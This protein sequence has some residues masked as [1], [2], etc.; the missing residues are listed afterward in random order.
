MAKISI[1][2]T[3]LSLATSGVLSSKLSQYPFQL[4]NSVLSDDR[5][6]I[7]CYPGEK[8]TEIEDLEGGGSLMLDV[9][10]NS[11]SH[12]SI[13]TFPAHPPYE[14]PQVSVC[15]THAQCKDKRPG[16]PCHLLSDDFR[17][18][19]YT[20]IG[21]RY[22]LAKGRLDL[23]RLGRHPEDFLECS[24]LSPLV[25]FTDGRTVKSDGE[26]MV[27]GTGGGDRL[28]DVSRFQASAHMS[29][30]TTFSSSEA[31]LSWRRLTH[32]SSGDG[33]KIS[34]LSCAFFGFCIGD[35]N[36]AI[37]LYKAPARRKE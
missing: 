35:G 17:E 15:R 30:I 13:L 3:S 33:V 19:R 27:R 6:P 34:M 9:T 25:T 28:R 1:S 4:L 22:H 37:V 21:E 29:S 36:E 7:R 20:G 26:E 2:N 18:E 24:C 31:S 11:G 32:S 5:S 16:C 12:S 14:S 10:S 8:G 23:R